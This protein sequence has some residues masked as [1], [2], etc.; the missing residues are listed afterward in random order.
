MQEK[1]TARNYQLDVMKLFFAVLVLISHSD[2]FLGEHTKFVIP[3]AAGAW[4]VFFFFIVSGMLMVH[5]YG[6]QPDR[7]VS[8]SKAASEFVTMRLK[9]LANPY[10]SAL[11]LNFAVFRFLLFLRGETISLAD[12]AQVIVQALFLSSTSLDHFLLN[13]PAWYISAMLIVMLPLYALLSRSKD[14]YLYIFAPLTAVFSYTWCFNQ[15]NHYFAFWQYYGL[16]SGGI[17]L[18]AMGLSFGAISWLIADRLRQY[19]GKRQRIAAT[20]AEIVLYGLIFHVW[21]STSGE[22]GRISLFGNAVA[23]GCG[24]SHIQ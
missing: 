14:F 3:Q 12:S 22:G 15:E 5:H 18:A 7:T 21:T 20:T 2:T 4:A 11:F 13:S 9:Q 23:A 1:I 19:R 10:W 17:V 16:V 6:K 24:C 8:P